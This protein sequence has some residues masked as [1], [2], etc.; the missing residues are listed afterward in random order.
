MYTYQGRGAQIK[1]NVPFHVLH[2]VA[3]TSALECTEFNLQ[4]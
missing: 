1:C 4:M 3:A 2:I